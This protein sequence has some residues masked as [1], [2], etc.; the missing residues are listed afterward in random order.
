MKIA[1]D[2]QKLHSCLL[3]KPCLI[4]DNLWNRKIFQVVKENVYKQ[5]KIILW[6]S[7]IAE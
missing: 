6:D 2:L 3:L 4:N 5:M 1:A 7:L